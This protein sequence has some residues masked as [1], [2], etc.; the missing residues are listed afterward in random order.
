M[1]RLAGYLFEGPRL[2]GGW[3][4]PSMPAVFAVL[5]KQNPDTRPDRYAVIYA[6]HSD[7]LALDG[8]PFRHPVAECWVARAGSRWKVHIAT[9]EV[10]GGTRAQ[11]VKQLIAVYSPHCNPQ[12]YDQAWKDHWIGEYSSAPNTGPLRQRGP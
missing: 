1:I 9:L 2:L 4:A 3:T 5:Y 6:G 7:D 10:T 11:I 8:F 12:K